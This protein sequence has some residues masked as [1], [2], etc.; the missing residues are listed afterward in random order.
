[1]S[2]QGISNNNISNLYQNYL[3]YEKENPKKNNASN[4]VVD[5]SPK[6]FVIQT[7]DNNIVKHTGFGK[8][9]EEDRDN[10]GYAEHYADIDNLVPYSSDGFFQPMEEFIDTFD[11]MSA[12]EKYSIKRA[13]LVSMENSDFFHSSDGVSD[14]IKLSNF[15]TEMYTIANTVVPEKYRSQFKENTNKCIDAYCKH[16][17]TLRNAIKE[18]TRK[19]PHYYEYHFDE[20]DS[21]EA[22]ERY[23]TIR[24]VEKEYVD[25]AYKPIMDSIEKGDLKGAKDQMEKF[26]IKYQM[27]GHAK[28]LSPQYFVN[29]LIVNMKNSWNS[30]ISTLS[31]GFENSRDWNSL[32]MMTSFT[33]L[34]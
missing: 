20:Y 21:P 19:N 30:I 10:D 22:I 6:E 7:Y 9:L 18:A 8:L 28:F 16:V 23:K 17:E 32:M 14:D 3:K 29:G 12:E 27:D 33:K 13:V 5:N 25:S 26:H 24:A 4:D 34:V 2:V 31:S 1:M 15:K 11:G